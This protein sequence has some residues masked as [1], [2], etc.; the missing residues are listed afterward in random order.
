MT[1]PATTT[2][3]SDAVLRAAEEVATA[4]GAI[5]VGVATWRSTHNVDAAL[6]AGAGTSAGK[7]L[8]A[9]A[10]SWGR[11]SGLVKVAKIVRPVADD[12]L[13]VAPQVA[14]VLPGDD[15]QILDQVVT[16]LQT[17]MADWDKTFP[18]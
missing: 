18:S 5:A 9:L 15:G 10:A 1:A 8:I 16:D 6:A 2:T 3:R 13:A 4:V 14:A 7:Q 17:A 12:I 11:T